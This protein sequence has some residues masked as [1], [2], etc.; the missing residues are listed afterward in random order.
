MSVQ[1]GSVREPTVEDAAA[2]GRVHA[3][4][5]DPAPQPDPC[6]DRVEPDHP[7][8]VDGEEIARLDQ[9]ALGS[10]RRGPIQE[11]EQGLP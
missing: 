10:E 2:D 9:I 5:R 11:R 1:T 8:R 4:L 7:A 3:A 6:P